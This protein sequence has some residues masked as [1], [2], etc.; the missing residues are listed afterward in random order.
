MVTELQRTERIDALTRLMD[1]L[2]SPDLT[3]GEAKVLDRQLRSLLG[4]KIEPA[5]SCRQR[6]SGVVR[7]PMLAH[8]SACGIPPRGA[9]PVS[10]LLWAC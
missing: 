9:Q 6:D 10:E 7:A 2:S 3:L 4:S 1:Q 8:C 5:A